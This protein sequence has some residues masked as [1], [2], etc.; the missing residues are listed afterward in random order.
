MQLIQDY[1]RVEGSIKAAY[2][3]D[4][5][6]NAVLFAPKENISELL[7]IILHYLPTNSTDR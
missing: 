4:A 1:N 7:S 3:F 2:S 6:P 5:G